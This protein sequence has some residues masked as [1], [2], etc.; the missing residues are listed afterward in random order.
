[1]EK[2]NLSHL[3][4]GDKVAKRASE[5]DW[6][7]MRNTPKLTYQIFTVTGRTKTQL[8]FKPFKHRNDMEEA[9]RVSDGMLVGSA[10]PD[11]QRV[12][13]IE[14]TDDIIKAH[15]AENKAIMR[16]KAACDG[17]NGLINRSHAFLDLT[18]EQLEALGKAWAE[19]QAMAK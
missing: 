19:I 8:K 7:V 15:E 10:G 18:T 14:A 2:Q 17:V 5:R 6:N 11:S 13:F 4:V 3:K 16:H 9:I 12:Y 1:M